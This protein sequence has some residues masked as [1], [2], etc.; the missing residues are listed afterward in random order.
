MTLAPSSAANA[1]V[2]SVEP[3]STT[4]TSAGCNVCAK[5][6]FKQRGR[7]RAALQAGMTTLILMSEPVV[8]T[9][10]LLIR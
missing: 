1:A 8:A 4:I 10:A 5:T 7:K 2:L 3:S 9:H 6:D